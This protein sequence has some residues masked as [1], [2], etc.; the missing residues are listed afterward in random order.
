MRFKYFNANADEYVL[1]PLVS[2]YKTITPDIVETG[3]SNFYTNLGEILIF[4]N[5]LLQFKA[6]VA[7]E[8]LVR[9]TVN[10]TLGI[11]GIFDFSMPIGL[12][13]QDEDFGRK[14]REGELL[15]H[16]TYYSPC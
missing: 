11:F 3:V 5:S 15:L 13:K 6:A 10:S 2:G 4:I 12:D 9:F 16:F 8:T 14:L 1:L 7:A